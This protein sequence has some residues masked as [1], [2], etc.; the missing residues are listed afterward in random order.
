M[1]DDLELRSWGLSDLESYGGEEKNHEAKH[2]HRIR[3]EK[4]GTKWN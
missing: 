3:G 2:L 1:D 4:F